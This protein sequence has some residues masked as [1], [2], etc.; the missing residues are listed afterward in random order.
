M[1]YDTIELNRSKTKMTSEQDLPQPS[2]SL[3]APGAEEMEIS[4]AER[5]P[6]ENFLNLLNGVANSESK[7]LTAAVIGVAPNKHFTQVQLLTKLIQ[8][9][10]EHVG[11]RI[12][13]RVPMSYCDDTLG[14][15]GAVVSEPVKTRRGTWTRA[16]KSTELGSEWGLALAGTLLD[17]SLKYPDIPLQRVFGTTRSR[18]SAKSPEARWRIFTE[19]LT[20][21]RGETTYI[22]IIRSMGNRNDRQ[23]SIHNHL[24]VLS[25]M[26]VLEITSKADAYN[27]IFKIET[28][29][30]R[31]IRKQLH[32]TSPVTQAIYSA[33]QK[34]DSEGKKE[35]TL[36]ELVAKSEEFDP[37]V[38]ARDIHKQLTQSL[39]IRSFHLPGLTLKDLNGAPEE[40]SS[41]KISPDFVEP[42]MD[43]CERLETVREP[44]NLGM[45]KA[46]AKQILSDP[47]LCS[48]LM[49]KARRFSTSVRGM[50]EGGGATNQRILNIVSELGSVTATEVIN[51]FHRKGVSIN[52]NSVRIALRNMANSGQLEAQRQRK[53]ADTLRL[54]SRYSL[55]KKEQ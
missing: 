29:E 13:K 18:S 51:E 43:L 16:Y 11:W 20:H 33:I 49:A 6:E 22:N 54:V 52:G 39:A 40:R 25:N 19:L 31:H 17:W 46:R 47:E 30:F 50:E 4:T 38:D 36:N 32:E 7:L 21:P 23:S 28:P 27:P 48:E 12:S 14:P 15:I 45:L 26:G 5:L 53:A 44:Q 24:E 3:T 8:L 35:A 37:S 55:A 2:E 9:Q 10:G 42:I 41:A 1:I 34:I